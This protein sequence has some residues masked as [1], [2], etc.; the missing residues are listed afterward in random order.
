MLD[1][2]GSYPATVTSSKHIQPY[3]HPTRTGSRSSDTG[4]L[5]PLPFVITWGIFPCFVRQRLAQLL[6]LLLI[7]TAPAQH[8]VAL[9]D[10][11]NDGSTMRG[12]LS[13]LL[14]CMRLLKAYA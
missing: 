14:A 1:H 11:L 2:T 13:A 9:H 12:C 8:E 5:L 7:F 3:V 6:L 10:M 4:A